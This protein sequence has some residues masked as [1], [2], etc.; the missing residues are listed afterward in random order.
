MGKSKVYFIKV[1]E[2]DSIPLVA[3][4]AARLIDESGLLDFVRPGDNI[5]IKMHFGEEGNTGYVKPEYVNAVCER[6]IRRKA[7]CF[8]SDTNTLYRGKRSN[9][10]EH[11]ELAYKHWFTREICGAEVLIPDDTRKE[12][13]SEVAINQRYIK[14]AKI[15]SLFVEASGILGIA[16]F[17]GHI[18]TGFAGALK[19]IGMGCATREGKLVQHSD[20]APLVKPEK[21]IACEDCVVNCP[22][23][24][25]IIKE[26]KAWLDPVKC[27]GC[28]TCIAVCV[29][30]AIDVE[31]E[32]GGSRLQEKMV[33]YAKA[34][35][36]DKQGR[37]AF[38]NF[39]VRITKECDCLA[40]DD[41]RIA[42]DVGIF[43]SNDP[44]GIDKACLD[45]SVKAAGRDIFKEAHPLREGLKQLTYANRLGLGSLEYELVEIG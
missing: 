29:Q 40:K 32:K 13:V 19:N 37:A 41:P 7:G 18:M 25:I 21:C 27:I 9:S 22:S 30:N 24:A 39:A 23:D 34:A 1:A 6:I 10:A 43:A 36:K 17:K 38:M 20:I 8:L 44:V 12:N 15:A 31:W 26:A 42:P 16:H 28:A 11:L 5:A 14:T 2:P 45:L 4:K 33:E 35:L 3:S